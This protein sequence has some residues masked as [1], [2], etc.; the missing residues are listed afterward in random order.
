MID[1]C[2]RLPVLHG[3]EI[4]EL[5]VAQVT[6]ADFAGFELVLSWEL[7]YAL[8]DAKLAILFRAAAAAG[9]PM[10]ACTSQRTGPLRTVLR[11]FKN[12]NWRPGGF[13]YE[14][15]QQQG[16]LRMHGWNHSAGYYNRIAKE[17]GMRLVHVWTPPLGQRRIEQFSFLH[18]EPL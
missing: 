2:S 15:M 8:D 14:R 10:L 13:Y 17:C 18:F 1:K 7:F 6:A 3:L 12:L 4:G 16:V 9:V 11:A 5:D